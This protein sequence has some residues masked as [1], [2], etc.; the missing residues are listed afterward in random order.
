[1]RDDVSFETRLAEAFG[2][3]A[4]LAPTMDDAAIARE[5]VT[6]GGSPHGRGW[7]GSLGGWLDRITVGRPGTRLAYLLVV[8]ALLLAAIVAAVAMGAFR[9]ESWRLLSRNGAIAY[10]VQA[11]DHGPPATHVMDPDGTGDHAID[12]ARC[13]TYSTDGSVL[14]YLSYEGSANLVV[15]GANGTSSKVVLVDEP[16]TSVSYALSPDGSKVA[17]FKPVPPGAAES[18]PPDNGPAASD[19]GLELW[20]APIAGGPGNRIVPGSNVP[21]EFYASPLWSPDGTRIAFGSYVADT[22]TGERHRSAIYAVAADGSNLR[23]LTTRPAILDDAMSWSPDGR[24]LAY[25]GIPDSPTPSRAT[26][27]G[28]STSLPRDIF[29]I[30]ADGTGDRSLTNTPAFESQPAWSPDGASLAFETSAEGE[31]HRLTTIHMNGP[32]P[33]GPPILGPESPWFVWS[34][35]GT[36]LL[37]LEVTSLGSETYRSMLHSIDRNFRQSPVTLQAVDGLIVCTPSWQRLEP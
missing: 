26:G 35:D 18:L 16:P 2:R 25:L 21:N 23:R 1:M 29:L 31:A 5:A 30:G 34:P 37:W 24:F 19:S 28:L 20:V 4:E 11:N 7:L 22:K 13:P 27:S 3:Y 32:T 14:A 17:W 15:L 10:T 6:D 8:L 36:K 33:E 9:N 12:S